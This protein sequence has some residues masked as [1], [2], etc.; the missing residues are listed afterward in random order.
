MNTNYFYSRIRGYLATFQKYWS[1]TAAYNYMFIEFDGTVYP[2]EL[3]SES[4]GSVKEQDPQTVWNG[5]QARRCR[6]LIENSEPCRKCI[7]PGAVRYSA[8]AEGLSYLGF[9]RKLGSGYKD[10]FYNEGFAKYFNG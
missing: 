6:A 3:L 7:E 4:M 9:L 1:C 10:S 5:P 8:C 2:C